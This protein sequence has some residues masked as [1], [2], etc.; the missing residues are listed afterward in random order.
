MKKTVFLL[1]T[2]LS[3]FAAGCNYKGE[4]VEYGSAC[5]DSNNKKYIE[6]SGLLKNKG[7][8][9]CSNTSGRMECGFRLMKD[10]ADTEGFTA[11]LA[12]GSSANTVE[13]IE[14]NFK[15][16]D[17]KIRD[18]AGEFVKVG[19]KVK[20]TGE[21]T[22]VKDATDPKGGVCYLKVDKIER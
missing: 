17:L 10:E 2:A 20:L 7:G 3:I 8:I 12:V 15:P 4:P 11:D 9:F 5:T 16:E 6:V 1:I 14:K 13:K 22:V 18:N 21:I 19:D